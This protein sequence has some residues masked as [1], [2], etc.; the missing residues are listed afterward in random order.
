M[1]YITVSN[2]NKLIKRL[3]DV[4]LDSIADNIYKRDIYFFNRR[5]SANLKGIREL[6]RDIEQFFREY[7]R[8]IE[9][10]D[11]YKYVYPESTPAYHKDCNCE[12][13]HSDFMNIEIPVPIQ[14]KGVSEI[15]KFREWYRK[16]EFDKDN[17]KDYIYK[18]QQQFPYVGAIN[19]QTVRHNNSGAEKKENYSL[20]DLQDEIEHILDMCEIYFDE[21][22]NL[23]DIIYRYQKMTFLGY[24]D[25]ALK[26]NR[27]GLSD[28]QLKSFLRAYDKTFKQPL[29][30]RLIEYYRVK[31]NPEMEFEGALLEKLGFRP[32]SK[33]LN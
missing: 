30:E 27:S 18:V 3:D 19:P 13:L 28:E 22:P 8:P 31:F 12:R 16:T 2:S 23:R 1:A 24:V 15:M 6:M 4:K 10:V 26:N 7:Y 11:S 21:N 32:C 29:K 14:Q 20:E 33:C 25:G 17:P 5:E 9:V